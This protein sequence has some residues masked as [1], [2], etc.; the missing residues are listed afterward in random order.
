MQARLYIA[1]ASKT[2]TQR[3]NQASE[4]L[5]DGRLTGSLAL[6]SRFLNK[7]STVRP[8][9]HRMRIASIGRRRRPQELHRRFGGLDAGA[10]GAVRGRVVVRRGRL[11]GEEQALVDARGEHGAGAGVARP[12][13]RIGAE[14]KWVAAPGGA[15]HRPQALAGIVAE[16]GREIVDRL[17]R[18]GVPARV[19]ELARERPAEIAFDHRP[20]ERTQLI[21]AG[22][23]VD[24][25]STRLNSSHVKIS[26]A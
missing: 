19:L 16:M 15:E 21:A 14:R 17:A 11:A 5:R 12:R 26:Y 18:E 8:Y 7:L 6:R 3:N 22:E 25:K 24:R 20:A 4:E 10:D 13:E 23:P 1:C 2:R 9:G